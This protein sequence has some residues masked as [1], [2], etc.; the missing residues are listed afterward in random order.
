MKHFILLSLIPAV[1][2]SLATAAKADGKPVGIGGFCGGTDK[3]E[4]RAGLACEARGTV[5]KQYTGI[6]APKPG[7]VGASC[8]GGTLASANCKEGLTC[9]V[10]GDK[11]PGKKGVCRKE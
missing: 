2:V 3:L 6:C 9:V 1:L 11:A 8:G 4:C 10:K 7:D 5:P